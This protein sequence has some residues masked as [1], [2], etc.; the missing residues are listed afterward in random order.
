M[1]LQSERHC[2]A[3]HWPCALS[4]VAISNYG[5]IVN[6]MTLPRSV[7]FNSD[8]FFNVENPPSER[9]RLCRL[10]TFPLCKGGLQSLRTF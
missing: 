3:Q 5:T 4:A 1:T 2:E 10:S 8:L 7:L 9:V 6:N